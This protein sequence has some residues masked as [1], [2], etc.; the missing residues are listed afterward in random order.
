MNALSGS[1][2]SF[3]AFTNSL[4]AR[5]RLIYSASTSAFANLGRFNPLRNLT[6]STL[7]TA[8]DGFDAGWLS[9]AARIFARIS[10]RDSTVKTVKPKREGAPARASWQIAKVKTTSP[11]EALRAELHAAVLEHAY[12]N[13][14]A[15]DAL[16]SNLCG[17]FDMLR[18]QMMGA[19]SYR[20]AVHHIIWKPGPARVVEVEIEGVIKRVSVPTMEATFEHVPLEYFE[21]HRG[22]LALLPM[23]YAG[24]G[25]EG[26]QLPRE[27]GDWMVT[28]GEGL[29]YAVAI[30]YMFKKL[31]LSDWI[32]FSQDYAQGKVLG[33][34]SAAEDSPA[35]VAFRELV[36]TFTGG[37]RAVVYGD[38]GNI[39]DPIETFQ[40][41]GTASADVFA[42]LVEKMERAIVALYRGADLGT[43]SAGSGEGSGASLQGDETDGLLADDVQMICESLWSQFDAFVIRYTLGDAR[44]LAYLSIPLSNDPDLAQI[45]ENAGF[46]ADRGVPLSAQNIAE[47]LGFAVAKSGEAL[48]SRAASP[49]SLSAFNAAQPRQ[50][51]FLAAS[52]RSAA[53]GIAKDF[54]PLRAPLAAMVAALESGDEKRI[55]SAAASLKQEIESKGAQIL[56]ADSE[57]ASRLRS[58]LPPA[59]LSGIA[60]STK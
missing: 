37:S 3:G 6:P 4:P 15:T 2:G 11:E 57:L 60:Q 18:R 7:A 58:I 34:T 13:L 39:A 36:S 17:G 45:R 27:S 56:K 51:K 40:N 43:M 1:I 5:G 54:E 42:K 59:L 20:Y 38:D 25:V 12:N 24:S 14:R 41:S 28:C 33:R 53:E 16:D 31:A 49:A 9:D 32:E 19:V 35:G 21:N 23:G 8:L 29:L 26:T 47:R 30:C 44:P 46:L 55:T 48:L 52:L 50:Q 22:R 10:D